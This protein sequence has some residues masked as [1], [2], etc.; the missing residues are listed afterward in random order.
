MLSSDFYCKENDGFRVVP[1]HPE[2]VA[3]DYG[4]HEVRESSM[5]CQ[6]SPLEIFIET[7]VFC[8]GILMK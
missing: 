8:Q 7:M 6:F 5:S 1:L 2:L 4:V 3:S